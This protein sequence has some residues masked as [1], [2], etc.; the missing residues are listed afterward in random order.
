MA[1]NFGLDEE[2]VGS[3]IRELKGSRNYCY[4][5]LTCE[6]GRE[7]HVERLKEFVSSRK[8][9]SWDRKQVWHAVKNFYSSKLPS[10][11][12]SLPTLQRQVGRKLFALSELDKTREGHKVKLTDDQIRRL[13]HRA[14]GPPS[15]YQAIFMLLSQSG[16]GLA[17]F[18][19]FNSTVWRSV[20][21]KLDSQEPMQIMLYR[22]KTS[23]DRR[24][25]Y[26][27]FIS[28]DSLNMLKDWLSFRDK[29]KVDDP[30]CFLTY[31]KT[32]RR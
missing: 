25:D 19:Q 32:D 28:R 8:T 21:D 3:W 18:Q 22:S 31:R 24:N 10:T 14:R 5:F 27:T 4:Y 6:E 20:V 30:H 2:F 9:G 7:N 17:E 23:A 15:P 1:I 13:V 29:L 26:Y 16:M 11:V 12:P